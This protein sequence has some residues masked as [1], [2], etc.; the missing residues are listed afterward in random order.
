MRMVHIKSLISLQTL[1]FST[2][3]IYFNASQHRLV[4]LIIFAERA[5]E[6][7]V[8]CVAEL[9]SEATRISRDRIVIG[10]LETLKAI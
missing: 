5:P 10:N 3:L 4:A 9:T 7:V 8:R 2:Q 1:R 6:G